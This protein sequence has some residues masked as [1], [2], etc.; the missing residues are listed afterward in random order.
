MPE[1]R[2]SAPPS[3]PSRGLGLEVVP[4]TASFTWDATYNDRVIRSDAGSGITITLPSTVPVGSRSIIHQY[5]AGAVTIAA[6]ANGALHSSNG[7]SATATQ[8]DTVEIV[9]VKQGVWTARGLG[10]QTG[11]FTGT[12][13]STGLIKG[14]VEDAITASTT[15]T[16]AGGYALTAQMNRVT[17]C[18]NSGDAV[19]LPLMT[20]G[21]WCDVYNAGANPAAVFPNSAGVAIDGGSAGA[22]VALANAKRCRYTYFATNVIVSAQLGA[23]SA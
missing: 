14:T 17:V 9:H 2:H 16:L 6:D 13:V 12:I 3:G 7:V 18:A 8:Y 4:V 23:I 20:V 15:Q 22:S 19:T 11:T 1:L 21:Q 5:G 10:A